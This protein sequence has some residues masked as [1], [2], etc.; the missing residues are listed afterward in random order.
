MNANTADIKDEYTKP[1][2]DKKIIVDD[3]YRTEI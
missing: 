2:K 3:R 1:S